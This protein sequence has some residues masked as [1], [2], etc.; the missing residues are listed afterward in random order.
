MMTL[1]VLFI[2]RHVVV[3]SK[4]DSAV[5]K[6]LEEQQQS[7]LSAVEIVP[8]AGRG[9]HDILILSIPGLSKIVQRALLHAYTWVTHKNP[10][11]IEQ[12][13]TVLG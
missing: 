1:T 6:T 8:H 11:E 7:A 9:E 3:F 2:E 5:Q 13:C 10:T 4:P 12:G